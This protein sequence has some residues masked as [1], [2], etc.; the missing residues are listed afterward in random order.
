MATVP[1]KGF[2]DARGEM[3]R[4]FAE[5]PGAPAALVLTVATRGGLGCIGPRDDLS[6][7]AYGCPRSA[8]DAPR[9]RPRGRSYHAIQGGPDNES[10]GLEAP[11]LPG[12]KTHTEGG[13]PAQTRGAPHPSFGTGGERHPSTRRKP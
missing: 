13:A 1:F 10:T 2:G 3:D 11:P 12:R 8:R 4:L 7:A 6:S 9:S 5:M